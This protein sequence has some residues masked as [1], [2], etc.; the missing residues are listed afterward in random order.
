MGTDDAKEER[1]LRSALYRFWNRFR[2]LV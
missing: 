2:R 1:I